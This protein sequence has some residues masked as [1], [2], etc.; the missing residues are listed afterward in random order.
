MKVC[1]TSQG[2]NLDAQVDPRFGRCQ[3]FI[4][5]DTD[6][7]VYEAVPNQNISGMGGVGVQSGQFVAK[8]GVKAVLTGKIGPKAVRTLEAANIGMFTDVSGN[9]RSAIEQYENGSLKS[10]DQPNVEEKSGLSGP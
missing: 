4:L 3:Y 8:K 5:V 1:V 7:W 6:T 9:V 10:S 2:N